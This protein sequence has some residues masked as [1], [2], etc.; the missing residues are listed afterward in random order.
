M[1][2]RPIC[3]IQNYKTPRKNLDDLEYGVAFIGTTLKTHSIK[4]DKLNFIKIKFMLC[5]DNKRI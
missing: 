1:N 5:K 4:S 2:H 3:K